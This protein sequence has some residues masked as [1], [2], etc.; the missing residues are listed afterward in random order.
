MEITIGLFLFLMIIA[1]ACEYVDS[2]LGMG[3]G[4]ILSPVLII[5][6]FE[7][8][9]SVPAILISQALGGLAA[10]IFHH[11]LKNVSYHPESKD[12][13]IVLII[14]GFGIFATILAALLAIQIPKQYVKV[15]IGFLVF[16][17][18]LIVLWNR[19]FTFSWRN[20]IG[21]G[22][23][24]AFNKG[25][26]GGGFGPV[27]TA[28]QIL[29]GQNHKGAIGATT[30]AEAPICITGFLTY[31]IARTSVHFK[32]PFWKI[33]VKDFFAQMFSPQLF[34]WE[35]NLALILGVILVAPF[36]PLL[37]AKLNE[38]YMSRILGILIIV[39]GALTL[40][41]AFFKPFKFSLGS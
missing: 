8:V 32:M 27:V 18:G 6:G 24:S 39:L 11:R 37:T 19:K 38:K 1:F 34:P 13:K 14:S 16:V 33:P 9:V 29:S 3:Y 10:S 40:Y 21:I 17:M 36:G 7:P 2:S 31:V 26:S 35:L 12:F 22:L 25:I 41:D 5:I 30:L 20:M 28:G 4:T 23:L 15:Y